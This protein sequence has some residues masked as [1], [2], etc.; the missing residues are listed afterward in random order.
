MSFHQR[1]DLDKIQQE[2]SLE[3]A[4]AKQRQVPTLLQPPRLP[5]MSATS[6]AFSFTSPASA[7]PSATS[8][9]QR[10]LPPFTSSMETKKSWTEWLQAIHFAFLKGGVTSDVLKMAFITD[11]LKDYHRMCAVT[12]HIENRDWPTFYE[13]FLSC[14]G[15]IATS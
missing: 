14:W 12:S 1:H 6:S 15:I 7:L 10:E 3:V 4:S 11:S 5:T 2:L 8:F 9:K 13:S